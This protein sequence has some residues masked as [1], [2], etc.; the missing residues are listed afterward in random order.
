MEA[1]LTLIRQIEELCPSGGAPIAAYQDDPQHANVRGASALDL[2]DAG[3]VLMHPSRSI[4]A[5]P[6]M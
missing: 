4:A 2:E 5:V 3:N 6:T 1:I